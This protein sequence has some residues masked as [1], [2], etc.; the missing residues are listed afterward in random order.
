MHPDDDIQEFVADT[1]IGKTYSHFEDTLES[2][3]KDELTPVIHSKALEDACTPFGL[4]ANEDNHKIPEVMFR[5]LDGAKQTG[6]QCPT[7]DRLF[8][9][10]WLHL[11]GEDLASSDEGLVAEL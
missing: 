11:T 5:T 6:N 9:A 1:F 8:K 2:V 10:A 3:L 4:T 7:L